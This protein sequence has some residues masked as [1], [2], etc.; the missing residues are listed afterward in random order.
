MALIDVVNIVWLAGGGWL[1]LGLMA[2]LFYG[3]L[4]EGYINEC[5]QRLFEARDELFL[6]AQHASFD[7]EC[8]RQIRDELNMFIRYA[9][10]ITW[11]RVRT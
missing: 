7:N 5:R 4:Q 2:Y 8:R 9:H 6:I 10:K 1:L 11:P 3:P